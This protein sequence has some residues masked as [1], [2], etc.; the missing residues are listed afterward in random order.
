MPNI[1]HV[2]EQPEY[3][4]DLRFEGI[5]HDVI[6]KDEERMGQLQLVVEGS[7]TGSHTKSIREDLRKPESFMIFSEES[8]RIIHEL[9][10]IELYELGRN[11]QHHPMPFVLSAYARRT[12][13]LY[14]R[15]MPLTRRRLQSEKWKHDAT[16]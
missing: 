3:K 13:I 8:R 2:E 1:T 14:M 12:T 7:R 4:V 6:L 11:V 5:A 10:N 15:N 16:P 9:G